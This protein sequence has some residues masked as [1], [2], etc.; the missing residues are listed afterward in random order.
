MEELWDITRVAE[1]LGVSE[2]TVYNR[3]R[4][5]ELPA[6][7]VGRLWRI[8]PSDLE[9]WMRGSQRAPS[10]DVAPTPIALVAEGAP[11]TED[12]TALSPN[13]PGPYP[14][15][16]V[17]EPV[18]FAAEAGVIPTRQD[19]ERLLA[20]LERPVERRLAFVGLLTKAVEALGWPPP[21]VVGGH[22]LEYYTAGDYPTIDIDLAGASE[23]IAHVL[24]D[25]GFGR[26]GRHWIDEDL[27]L[28]LEVPGARPGVDELAHVVSVRFRGVII[29][30]VG[31]EDLLVDRLCAA[32]FWKDI[33]SAMWVETVLAE[34]RE[35]DMKYLRRRATEEDVLD[36]LEQILER[37]S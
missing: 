10:A 6:I 25:W 4:S 5:G 11:A 1:Y 19:L 22:A 3:V 24:G 29:Y 23:P 35:L 32:I 15:H 7:K 34:A 26:E 37:L 36:R 2:R 33:D 27:G 13:V 8:R 16:A 28:V 21:V 12:L 30:L 18:E 31:I 20:G 14:T 17:T 9:A